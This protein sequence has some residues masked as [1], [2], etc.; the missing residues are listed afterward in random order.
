MEKFDVDEKKILIVTLS[1]IF[2]GMALALGV[3]FAVGFVA[4]QD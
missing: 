2:V 1:S 3:G 4:Y